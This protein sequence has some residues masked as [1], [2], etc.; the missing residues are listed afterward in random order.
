PPVH[1][2]RDLGFMLHD[3]DFSNAADP[4][5]RFFRARMEHGVVQVPAWDSAEVRG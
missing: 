3:L 1:D 2:S 5:P 4:Q